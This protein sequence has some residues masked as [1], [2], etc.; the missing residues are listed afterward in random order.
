MFLIKFHIDH[1]RRGSKFRPKSIPIGR[2]METMV[3]EYNEER[4]AKEFSE[5]HL[6][7]KQTTEFLVPSL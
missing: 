6:D 2:Q 3:L 4:L 1:T 5:T 7:D